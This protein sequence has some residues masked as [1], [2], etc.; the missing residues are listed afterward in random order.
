MA[1]KLGLALPDVVDAAADIADRDGLDAVTLASVAGRLGMRPP[2]LYAHVAG[3]DGLRRALALRAASALRDA[4]RD[5]S[6]DRAGPDALRAIAHAY[7]TFAH[8]HPGLYAAAQ[9]AVRPGEDDE[10]YRA[11]GEAVQPAIDAFA[12]A[13]IPANERVHLARAFR[14][15]LHG[16]VTLEH[17]G[18]FGMPESIDRSFDRLVDLLLV[19][20]RSARRG[21]G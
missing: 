19:G 8:S 5:A 17:I 11:L 9:R 14:A 20:V 12:N 7:R 18:G 13:G 2:S 1:R 6:A 10:L 21:S 4:L 16:F 15:A 3:L